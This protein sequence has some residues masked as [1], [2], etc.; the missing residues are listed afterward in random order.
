MRRKIEIEDVPCVVCGEDMEG[1]KNNILRTVCYNCD[2]D[3]L[4][5][6]TPANNKG[7]NK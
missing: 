4:A 5:V 7:I 3:V 2:Q 6:T 1:I